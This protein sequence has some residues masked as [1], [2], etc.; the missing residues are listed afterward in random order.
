[1]AS[2]HH[3]AVQVEHP[4]LADDSA[5]P[6][7]RLVQWSLVL[8][9]ASCIPAVGIIFCIPAIICGHLALGHA[10]RASQPVDIRVVVGLTLG[11]VIAVIYAWMA[12]GLFVVPALSGR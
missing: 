7:S 3:P 12:I 11:Y 6:S 10:R 8:G 1:M 4:D 5:A 2:S 9:I